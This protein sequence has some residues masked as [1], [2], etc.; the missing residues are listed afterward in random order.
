MKTAPLIV[1]LGL[2]LLGTVAHGAGPAH[3]CP[4]YA[5]G[6]KYDASPIFD[7]IDT[8]KDGKAT[9][10]EW[11]KAGAPE[12]SWNMFMG[13][14]GIKEQGYITRAQFLAEAPPNGIDT[15]CDGKITMEEF[16]ATKKWKVGPPPGGGPGGPGGP[17][18]GAAPQPKPAG[19]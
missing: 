19:K 1:T 2:G 4:P 10:A 18:P 16:L 3:A 13:K 9:L 17:L 11:R 6:R 7:A 14:P 8:N 12:P 15:N 5:D